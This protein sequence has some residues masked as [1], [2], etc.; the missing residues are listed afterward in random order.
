MQSA[1]SRLF[2]HDAAF[3]LEAPAL[4]TEQ[5]VVGFLKK[6]KLVSLRLVRHRRLFR[7]GLGSALI[8]CN[9]RWGPPSP[10]GIRGGVQVQRL[11][12]LDTVVKRGEH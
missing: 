9:V 12:T 7:T 10:Q 11:G 6:P 5:R 1:C 8:C 2:E 3:D 4:L